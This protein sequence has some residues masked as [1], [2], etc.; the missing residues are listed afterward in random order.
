MSIS[1]VRLVGAGRKRT[2]LT[3]RT[4]HP[5][6]LAFVKYNIEE[7]NRRH[8]VG[9][10]LIQLER[11]YPEFKKMILKISKFYKIGKFDRNN[12]DIVPTL[13]Y[14]GRGG[15]ALI[16]LECVAADAL[17][18]GTAAGRD[19]EPHTEVRAA[20]TLADNYSATAAASSPHLGMAG[21]GE[22]G[23]GGGLR[24]TLRRLRML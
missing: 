7:A 5:T 18:A 2:A 11:E 16:H 10:D 6:L 24:V 22:K 17:L 8:S 12:A 21:K 13:E 9:F 1:P 3:P 20:C 23:L 19:R 14:D 15:Q 4:L